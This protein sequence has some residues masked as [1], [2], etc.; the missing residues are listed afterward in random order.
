MIIADVIHRARHD[1]QWL[2][3]FAPMPQAYLRGARWED[4]L[5][6]PVEQRQTNA[7]LKGILALEKFK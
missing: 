1:E 2:R 3:G 7:T 6:A 4:E 5:T